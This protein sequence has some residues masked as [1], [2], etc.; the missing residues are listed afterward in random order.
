M[1]SVITGDS[2]RASV[3]RR[4]LPLNF[5]RPRRPVP[6]WLLAPRRQQIQR[7]PCDNEDGG[8][9]ADDG[10]CRE[11]QQGSKAPLL[12]CRLDARKSSQGA[13]THNHICTSDPHLV[14]EA[15]WLRVGADC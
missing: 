5:P 10:L 15:A 7:T 13:C 11:K 3:R 6:P 1:S 8:V 4:R 14:M 9:N 2:Q 12:A